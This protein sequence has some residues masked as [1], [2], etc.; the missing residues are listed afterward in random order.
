MRA[1]LGGRLASVDLFRVLA[2]V[3]VIVIHTTPFQREDVELGSRLDAAMTLNQLARFAVPFFFV[4]SGY[5]WGLK[6]LRAQGGL[7]PSLAMA[8][9]I[10]VLFLV[11][12]VVYLV[13]WDLVDALDRGLWEP[14]KQI[15]WALMHV[16]EFP[17]VT[18]LQG[19]K[20]HL[21][22]LSSLFQ[23][24][25]IGA[26]LLKL[27]GRVLFPV[28]VVL[29]LVG[30]AGKAY[31]AT[32]IGFDA[33]FDF[34]NGPFMA[35]LFFVSGYHLSSLDS[36]PRWF[37]AGLLLAVLGTVLHFLE[38]WILHTHWGT[39]LDQDYVI[40]T[41]PMGVGVA[42]MALSGRSVVNWTW[43]TRVGPLVLGVYAS[44]F[45]FV[46]LLR[47]FDRMA[48]GSLIWDIG[49]VVLVFFLSLGLAVILARLPGT[50]RMVS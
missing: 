7:R 24:L 6:T 22:F 21:W 44:H 14:V 27:G 41:Y 36:G 42:L 28:A 49:Y 45:M 38:I 39:S 12:S 5:F 20:G 34:R 4:V 30:L 48:A 35:L 13:Q 37:A 17:V 11:W 26:V 31:S 29:Y 40:G 2:I 25:C 8:K 33:A 47:P 50:R 18:L 1:S 32:P 3:A 16:L 23:S 43:A 10:G 46:D 9:R 19:T 15:Y